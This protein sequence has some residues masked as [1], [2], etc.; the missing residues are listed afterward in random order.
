[1]IQK[2]AVVKMYIFEGAF[3]LKIFD[4]RCQDMHVETRTKSN[5]LPAQKQ[6]TPCKFNYSQINLPQFVD[7]RC[8]E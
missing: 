6:G 8:R 2:L 3:S 7:R 4:E 1:M 5:C